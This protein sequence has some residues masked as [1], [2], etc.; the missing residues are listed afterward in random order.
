[1]KTLKLLS[2]FSLP[3]INSGIRSLFCFAVIFIFSFSQMEAQNWDWGVA[4]YCSIK[5]ANTGSQPAEDKNKNVFLTGTF[6]GNITFG[7]HTLTSSNQSAYLTKLDS[8]GN[9][10]WVVAPLVGPKSGCGATSVATDNSGNVYICG[11]FTGTVQFGSYNLSASRAW[12]SVYLAK[13]SPTGTLLWAKQGIASYSNYLADDANSVAT[14]ASGNVFVTG[15]FGSDTIRFGSYEVVNPYGRSSYQL[16]VFIVK[17]DSSGNALWAAQGNLPSNGCN[18]QGNSVFTDNSGN[19]YITGQFGNAIFFGS[20]NL[21]ALNNTSPFLVKY[22]PSGNVIWATEG[23]IS[24]GLGVM[25]Y[26]NGV[27]T[28]KGNNIYIT[29]YFQD[30]LQ[31]GSTKLNSP[32]QNSAFLTKYDS[33]GHVLWVEQSSQGWEGTGVSADRRGYIYLTGTN[34]LYE[35]DIN[36]RTYTLN[37][38]PWAKTNAFLIKFDDSGNPICGS[39]LENVGSDGTVGIVS[40]PSGRYVYMG[41]SFANDTVKC[42][43]DV[44]IPGTG[45]QNAFVGRWQTCQ[46]NLDITMTI[47]SG[48]TICSTAGAILLFGNP[49]GGTYSGKGVYGN[50]FYPDSA[51]TGKYNVFYYTYTDTGGCTATT[52]DSVYVMVCDGIENIYAGNGG[53]TVYPNPFTNSTTISIIH[54]SRSTTHRLELDDVTGQKLRNMEFTG[55]EYILSVEGMAKGLYFIRV[56]DNA[57]NAI[58]TSKIVVQ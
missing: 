10:I 23:T 15:Y 46:C 55:N 37:V 19:A 49:S 17:Y 27:T 26:G 42:G 28:D 14:D 16:D 3:V 4:G 33:N 48:D 25:D 20:H 7:T 18:A 41:G 30:S 36:F 5:A 35:S 34:Y 12:Y 50:Y 6:D 44:L 52:K 57:N 47:Q 53:L 1:M 32:S 58:G 54:N 40:D 8:S 43:P 45:G 21:L 56:F 11:N 2:C 51:T 22:S 9:D 39:S 31:F 24:G 29:G 38:V 13:Y